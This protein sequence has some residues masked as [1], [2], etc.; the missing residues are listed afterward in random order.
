[1]SA[2]LYSIVTM[3]TYLGFIKIPCSSISA[4]TSEAKDSSIA[5]KTPLPKTRESR[6][7]ILSI[8]CLVRRPSGRVAPAAASPMSGTTRYLKET[9]NCK[10]SCGRSLAWVL[11]KARNST[12]DGLWESSGVGVYQQAL[13]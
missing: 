10:A 13:L 7:S 9:S 11:P 5:L 4:K 12:A 2:S 8:Q 1:M 6:L 3:P